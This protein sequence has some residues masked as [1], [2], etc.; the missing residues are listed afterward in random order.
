MSSKRIEVNLINSLL[1]LKRPIQTL[2]SKRLKRKL[3]YSALPCETLD[4]RLLKNAHILYQ[5]LIRNISSRCFICSKCK[6]PQDDKLQIYV[7]QDNKIY[8]SA[9]YPKPTPLPIEVDT[10]KIMAKDGY[11]CPK[12]GGMVFDAE[13]MTIKAGVFHKLCFNCNLCGQALNYSNFTSYE[14]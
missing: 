11:G 3:L 5:V 9:H 4:L 13:K 1:L 2:A 12:C 10:T 8:C 6:R 7:G 14:K